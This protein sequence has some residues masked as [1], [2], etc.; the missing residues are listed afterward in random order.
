MPAVTRKKKTPRP[1]SGGG[2]LH[3]PEG[4]GRLH[5]FRND[6][7]KVMPS[8]YAIVIGSGLRN[9]PRTKVRDR[10]RFVDHI[11]FQMPRSV[12]LRA[13]KLSRSFQA[14]AFGVDRIYSH[15]DLHQRAR[16]CQTYAGF[17]IERLPTFRGSSTCSRLDLEAT[18]D[19]SS[20]VPR[21][22]IRSQ[23]SPSSTHLTAYLPSSSLKAWSEPK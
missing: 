5:K 13:G 8:C 19:I 2:I 1:P 14:K 12:K 16:H 22:L 20:G 7:R 6:I 17:L 21:S 11:A 9:I 18:D 4:T 3:V 10:E 15:L 23:S